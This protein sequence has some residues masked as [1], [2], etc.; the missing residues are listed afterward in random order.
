MKAFLEKALDDPVALFTFVLCLAT[1]GLVWAVLIQMKDARRTSKRQLR[2]YVTVVAGG[3]KLV[4]L[5][6]GGF[7]VA[8]HIQLRNFAQTPAYKFTT[9]MKAPEIQPPEALP[10]TA[11]TPVEKR[12]GTSIVGPGADIHLDWTISVAPDQLLEIQTDKRRVYVWGGADFVDAFD[13]PRHLIFRDRNG[14]G[15]FQ[16]AGDTLALQPHPLGY[17]AN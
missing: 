15:R 6:E 12:N 8:V 7:G 13:E 10:F 11:A 5:V 16:E 17:D 14:R 1:L 2:A 9:W 3:I 4:H